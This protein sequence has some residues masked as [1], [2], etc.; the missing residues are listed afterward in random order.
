MIIFH[1]IPST[2][3]LKNKSH[4]Y[5]DIDLTLQNRTPKN[6]GKKGTPTT[7]IDV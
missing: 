2:K 6:R 3:K 1:I 5:Q 7:S 4:T